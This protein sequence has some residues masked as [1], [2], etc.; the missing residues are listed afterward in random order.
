S[1]LDA[2]ADYYL[3]KPFAYRELT[4]CVRALLR[5]SGRGTPEE[6]TD[7]LSQADVVLDRTAREVTR[8]GRM[9]E[10]TSREFDLL[11]LLMLNARS[12]LP[13]QLI[14]HRVWGANFGGESNVTDVHIYTLRQKLGLPNLIQAVRG[15]GYVSRP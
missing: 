2:G 13:R 12:V 8:A 7:L 10:L 15:A 9:V 6:S 14:L 5:R 4:A 3:V 1:G 11:A